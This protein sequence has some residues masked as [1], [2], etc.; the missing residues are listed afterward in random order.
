MPFFG[1]TNRP[2][3]VSRS[4]QSGKLK[5]NGKIFV[6]SAHPVHPQI[7]LRLFEGLVVSFTLHSCSTHV[8][9]VG[10]Q[11]HPKSLAKAYKNYGVR[12]GFSMSHQPMTINE[13]SLSYSCISS[14]SPQSDQPATTSPGEWPHVATSTWG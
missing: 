13:T 14:T 9:A 3:L 4:E 12:L 2:C 8:T 6:W 10:Q 5:Y 7:A 11:A 1:Q